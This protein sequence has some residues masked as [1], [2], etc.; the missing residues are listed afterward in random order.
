VP[1][2]EITI[3]AAKDASSLGQ[4]LFTSETVIRSEEFY[5]QVKN[6]PYRPDKAGGTVFEELSAES[7]LVVLNKLVSRLP[8]WAKAEIAGQS[9]WQWSGL[10][11]Y[12]LF[13]LSAVLLLYRYGG[14]VLGLLDKRLDWNLPQYV[15]GLVVPVALILLAETGLW[16]IVYGLHILNSNVYLPAAY[17]LS[18]TFYLGIVW[19]IWALLNRM[20]AVAIAAGGFVQGTINTQLIHFCFQVLAFIIICVTI[21]FLGARLGLPTYSLVTGLGIGGLA[22]ALAGREALS[23]LI[24]TIAILVDQPFKLGDFV[25]LGEGD[26]GTITKIGLRSTRIKRLDGIL[27]SVPNATIANMKITNESAPAAQ[28]QI[29]VPVR[30]AYGSSVTE[31]EQALLTATQ[32]C[33]YV[34]PKPAPSVRLVRFADSALEFEVLVWII[35]PEFRAAATDQINR[36]VWEEFQRREIRIRES[37]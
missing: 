24:G 5:N 4:F 16:F 36:A 15:G 30:A 35:Q 19:L 9:V 37:K 14:E 33:E 32:R 6:L 10:A 21:I 28:A 3:A 17:V 27:V 31:V 20:A 2:T 12:F 13:G 22:V 11:L 23:N 25:M 34:L 18:V 7:G 29:T 8:R 26:R 1:H